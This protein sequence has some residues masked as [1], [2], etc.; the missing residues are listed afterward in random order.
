MHEIPPRLNA[1]LAFAKSHT[2]APLLSFLGRFKL[3]QAT[4]EI[5][6]Q[7]RALHRWRSSEANAAEQLELIDANIGR[8][9][10][11][12]KLH[13][14]EVIELKLSPPNEKSAASFDRDAAAMASAV[15]HARDVEHASTL[16]L[17]IAIWFRTELNHR[18]RD[19]QFVRQE[20]YSQ[21]HQVFRLLNE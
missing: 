6:A 5:A 11:A 17:A 18:E 8:R 20:I 1:L 10:A 15:R 12:D 2:A 7:L 16:G 21:M 3:P 19:L 14:T 4:E 9:L 13:A